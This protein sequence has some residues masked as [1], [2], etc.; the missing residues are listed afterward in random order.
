[1]ASAAL[2]PGIFHQ[3][4][5]LFRPLPKEFQAL[6]P[7][8][9]KRQNE[10]SFGGVQ[11]GTRHIEEPWKISSLL[12]DNQIFREMAV[13]GRQVLVDVQDALPESVLFSFGV[14]E[15]CTRHEK[16]LKFLT[17]NSNI[18]DGNDL[19]ISLIS[20]LMG[21]QAVAVDICPQSHISEDEEFCPY[22]IGTEVSQKIIHPQKQIY[23][24]RSF[25]D[26]VGNLSHTPSITVHPN[27]HV[28]FSGNAA[29]MK[30]VLSIVAEFNIPKCLS[31]GDRRAMV[32]PY[33]TRRRGGHARATTELSPSVSQTQ[34]VG[35]SKSPGKT[36]TM[37][38]KKQS[39]NPDSERF[40]KNYFYACDCLFNM[41]LDKTGNKM[42]IL[43]LKDSGPE[44]TQLLSQFSAVIVG[45]GL[46]VLFSVALKAMN[47]TAALLTSSKLFS[48][49]FG[50]GLFWL[51]RAVSSLRDTIYSFSKRSGRGKKLIEEAAVVENV[52]TSINEIL[53]RFVAMMAVGI[54]SF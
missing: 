15:Q 7:S 50:I 1:M 12:S 20:D 10:L 13:I 26:F 40:S 46:A 45:T 44:L 29:E 11:F 36:K 54:L 6:T 48:V 51:S 39:R 23:T 41:Y 30:D 18:T 38:K 27:G 52:R 47:G 32:V 3:D 35:P 33:F 53:F 9:S 25:L 21:F 43:S 14:A 49:S 4:Q 22:E 37:H 42:I 2:F 24:P 17:S 31:A 5:A 28:M 16:I 34:T 19:N 8:H